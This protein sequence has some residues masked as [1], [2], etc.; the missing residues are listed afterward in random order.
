MISGLDSI[1]SIALFVLKKDTRFCYDCFDEKTKN[2]QE[3]SVF[4]RRP[5]FCL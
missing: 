4:V 3:R 1:L 5:S 2:K